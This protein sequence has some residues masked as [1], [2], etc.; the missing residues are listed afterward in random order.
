MD[1]NYPRVLVVSNNS[2]SKTSSN[3]RTLGNLFA[4]WP[5]EKLAQFCIST[6]EPDFELCDNYYLLTDRSV[7]EG[8]KHFRGGHRCAIEANLGTEGNTVIGGKKAFKTPWKALLR[9]IVWC[10]KR[11]DSKVFRNWVDNCKP[12]LVL[13]MNSDAPFILDIAT[14][15]S[16][17]RNIPLVMFNTEG[18]YFFK[19]NYYRPSRYFSDMAFSLYQHV[20]I[21]HFRKM[22]KR[23]SL[24]IHLNSALKEDFE[25][26]FGGKHIVLYTGSNVAFDS[27]N[28]NVKQPVF[29]YLGNFGFDRPK[30]L[31][32]V[33]ETLQCINP[34]YYLNVYG[35]VLKKE[36]I[37]VL[38][39]TKGIRFHGMIP[40]NKVV[41]VMRNS[42]ILFHVEAQ[43]ESFKEALKYGFST[44]IGDSVSSGRCF[45]I[46][47][48][49]DVAGAKYI[50]ETGA[51]WF[52]NNKT[53]LRGCIESI[54]MDQT[55]RTRVLAKAKEIALENH[56][57]E[58]NCV[59]FKQA[60]LS[61]CNS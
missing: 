15:I 18:F 30:A 53:D 19:N 4:G 1:S 22:M 27:S 10:G 56:S 55:T 40:Y 35:K 32:E 5:K 28:L 24:S 48:A 36:I 13:V 54:L 52:A 59:K 37:N 6:T 60:L 12:E 46:Y 58:N 41:E 51:G 23:V 17:S 21:R 34:D 57:I 44:K 9:H 11:W 47:S 29:S 50:K 7:L 14:D 3:G 38:E 49:D 61:V 20:Y 33:A 43:N 26:E 39:T 42:T 25:K 8:F 31:V 45:L 16:R 2:F